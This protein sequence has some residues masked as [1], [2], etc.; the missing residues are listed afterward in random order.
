M[1]STKSNLYNSQL[2]QK[3]A[4]W[5]AKQTSTPIYWEYDEE[6]KTYEVYKD[7]TAIVNAFHNH[8]ENIKIRA[9][10]K[11]L[12]QPVK[13]MG[14]EESTFYPENLTQAVRSRLLFNI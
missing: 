9:S 13:F 1:K 5:K 2:P 8:L 6:S 3:F 14:N 4:D 11:A 12:G 10:I 7:Y